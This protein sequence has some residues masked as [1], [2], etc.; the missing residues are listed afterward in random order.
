MTEGRANE[1]GQA[2]DGFSK[3]KLSDKELAEHYASAIARGLQDT[4]LIEIT[5]SKVSPN[6]TG[7]GRIDYM[8]RVKKANQGK[9]VK[10]GPVELLLRRLKGVCDIFAG[11]EFFLNN[12]DQIRYAYVISMGSDNLE[13]TMKAVSE[14]L[15]NCGPAMVVTESPL[16]GDGTPQGSLAQGRGHGSRGAQPIK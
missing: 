7:G 10:G 6:G 5:E 2:I 4:G 12:E 3:P 13:L 9:F 16:L 15:E 11:I 1:L 14:A 8:G